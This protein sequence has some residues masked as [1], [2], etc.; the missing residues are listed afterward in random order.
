[1]SRK[2]KSAPPA[3]LADT[4]SAE[5]KPC[6]NGAGVM[7]DVTSHVVASVTRHENSA[8]EEPV[9]DKESVRN[10]TLIVRLPTQAPNAPQSSIIVIDDSDDDADVPRDVKPD[11][12]RLEEQI[13]ECAANGVDSIDCKPPLNALIN[14]V[15]RIA[16]DCNHSESPENNSELSRPN[17][18]NAASATVQ[19]QSSSRKAVDSVQSVSQSSDGASSS[20]SASLPS[21]RRCSKFTTPSPTRVQSREAVSKASSRKLMTDALQQT[22]IATQDASVQAEAISSLP[23]QQ[24]E[25]LR[26]NVLQLL[27]TIVPTLTC[28]NLEFVDEIVVEMVRVNAESIEIDD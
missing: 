4:T 28:S 15:E 17:V 26:S 3:E 27:K 6:M 22:E 2:R 23:E 16:P 8:D 7:A 20:S 25:S 5:K 18:H 19:A 21:E 24:L 9:D 10:T 1:M 11:V 12:Q 13:V 14:T